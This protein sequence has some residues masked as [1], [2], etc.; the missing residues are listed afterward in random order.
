MDAETIR[1]YLVHELVHVFMEG[2]EGV[3]ESF[4]AA[5]TAT[6]FDAISKVHRCAEEL[7]TDRIA[8]LIAT[9][10]PLPGGK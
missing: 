7:A 1:H 10:M 2:M 8:Q 4:R 3:L 9:Y 5:F 6:S